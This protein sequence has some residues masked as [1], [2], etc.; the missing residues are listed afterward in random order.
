MEAICAG[1]AEEGIRPHEIL[2]AVDVIRVRMVNIAEGFNGEASASNHDQ[3]ERLRV[4]VLRYQP[5]WWPASQLSSRRWWSIMLSNHSTQIGG[6]R[7]LEWASWASSNRL[8]TLIPKKKLQ[9]CQF[10]EA[11]NRPE[12]FQEQMGQISKMGGIAKLI[13]S[14][15]WNLSSW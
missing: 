10:R 11:I 9:E 7:I 14:G 12:W 1:S 2:A 3:D 4:E 15:F 5:R 13:D 6:L 8:K